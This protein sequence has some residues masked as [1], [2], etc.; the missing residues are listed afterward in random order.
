[1]SKNYVLTFYN[2]PNYL[3]FL[4]V[5]SSGSIAVDTTSVSKTK[6]HSRSRS[7][8]QKPSNQKSDTKSNDQLGDRLAAIFPLVRMLQVHVRLLVDLEYPAKHYGKTFLLI[9]FCVGK[10]QDFTLVCYI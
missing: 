9:T 7:T 10:W 4:F 8:S 3:F 2:T 6:T 1:M 5:A